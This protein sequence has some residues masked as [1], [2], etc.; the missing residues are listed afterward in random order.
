MLSGGG[1]ATELRFWHTTG[2]AI[3][4][5]IEGASLYTIQR[6][7]ERDTMFKTIT[8]SWERENNMCGYVNET[9]RS[10]VYLPVGNFLQVSKN[11]TKNLTL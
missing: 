11:W 4:S 2:D 3:I 10:K 8:V 5:P 9:N 7:M 1:I 6:T